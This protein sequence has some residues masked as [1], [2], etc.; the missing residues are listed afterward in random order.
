MV[1]LKAVGSMVSVPSSS[2]P[3]FLG[4]FFLATGIPVGATNPDSALDDEDEDAD[5]ICCWESVGEVELDLSPSVSILTF[6]VI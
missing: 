3:P 1:G 6:F 2:L 5:I 4:R